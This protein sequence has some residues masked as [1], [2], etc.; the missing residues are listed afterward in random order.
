MTR[1]G[2][3]LL[4]T[5]SATTLVAQETRELDAHVHGVSTLE[6][7]VED[8]TLEINLLSPGLDIVGFEYAATTDADKDAVAAA[9]RTLLAPEN[10]VALPGAAGCR[11]IEAVA[12]HNGGDDDHEED[13]HDH[14]EGEDHD[15]DHD[16]D[17]A[18]DDDHEHEENAQH[19]EFHANYRFSCDATNELTT[20]AFPF[21]ET[22]PNA[23]EIEARYVTDTGTG[24]V[25]ITADDPELTLD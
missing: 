19:S 17:H 5:V 6:L 14:A 13:M 10:V 3:I 21:F 20:I 4:G 8:G 22:F 18:E 15:H 16:H 7:A 12:H 25:E 2:M 24:A 1:I 23:E 9:I 11:L